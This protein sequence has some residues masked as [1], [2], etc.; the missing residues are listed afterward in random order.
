M[1]CARACSSVQGRA[2]MKWSRRQSSSCD[3]RLELSAMFSD[4]P[5]PLK[6]HTAPDVVANNQWAVSHWHSDFA[7][8]SHR[9]IQR[10]ESCRIGRC[11]G[12]RIF[13]SWT[14]RPDD[15]RPLVAKWAGIGD[16]MA[17]AASSQVGWFSCLVQRGFGKRGAAVSLS[18][19]S[20]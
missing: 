11:W 3:S 20:S 14:A 15:Q 8:R 1:F 13:I 16:R 2:L 6:L 10:S 12:A 9:L 19:L 7:L 4:Q 5:R 17:E 18:G